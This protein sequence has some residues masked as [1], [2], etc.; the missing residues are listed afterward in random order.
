MTLFAGALLRTIEFVMVTTDAS[1]RAPG[2]AG[3][4][5]AGSGRGADDARGEGR[6][7]RGTGPPSVGNPR[8]AVRPRACRGEARLQATLE[9]GVGMDDAHALSLVHGVELRWGFIKF[10][11][12]L[13]TGQSSWEFLRSRLHSTPRPRGRLVLLNDADIS[14]LS[15]SPVEK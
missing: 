7:R 15:L 1:F 10:L 14:L 2:S 13:W 5:A 6:G 9:R 11:A 8:D 12:C 4:A 3:A